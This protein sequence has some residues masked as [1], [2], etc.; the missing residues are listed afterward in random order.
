MSTLAR[1]LWKVE[2]ISFFDNIC[3]QGCP[4]YATPGVPMLL[5][6]NHFTPAGS[7][8]FAQSMRDR[9]QLARSAGTEWKSAAAGFE[10]PTQQQE[11]CSGTLKQ[12]PLRP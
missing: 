8:R 1:D 12:K 4:S 9:K 10:T 2:Y 6:T 7:I 5:D 3:S 11:I